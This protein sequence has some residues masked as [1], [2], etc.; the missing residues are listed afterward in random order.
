MCQLGAC[1]HTEMCNR[2]KR[3]P[4][5]V[6]R[7]GIMGVTYLKDEDMWRASY[8]MNGNLEII[9]CFKTVLEAAKARASWEQM[10]L[11]DDGR[12]TQA[13]EYVRENE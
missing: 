2:C 10:W 3:N 8:R 4:H 7:F 11:E 9:G 12:T 6:C 5:A 13:M 1:D